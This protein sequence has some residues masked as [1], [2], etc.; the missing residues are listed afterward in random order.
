MMTKA[1][2]RSL[3]KSAHRVICN[4]YLALFMLFTSTT[5]ESPIMVLA[6]NPQSTDHESPIKTTQ[7]EVVRRW[8][9][10]E[11]KISG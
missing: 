4:V 5:V 8:E 1:A 6:L 7:Y 3:I 10:T 11:K 2:S 9:N